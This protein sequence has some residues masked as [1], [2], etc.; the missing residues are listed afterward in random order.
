MFYHDLNFG[1]AIYFSII[2]KIVCIIFY[3]FFFFRQRGIIYTKQNKVLLG[4]LGNQ[5]LYFLK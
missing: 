3:L 2:N 4:F 5:I 1:K